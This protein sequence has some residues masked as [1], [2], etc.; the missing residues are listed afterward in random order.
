M[1][2]PTVDHP[3]TSIARWFARAC[4]V[5]PLAALALVAN[6]ASAVPAHAQAGEI[7]GTVTAVG[8]GELLAGAQ[9]TV[10]GGTQRAVTDDRGRFRLAGLTGTTATLEVRRIGYRL[11][12]VVARV[13]QTD[14]GVAL[15]VN[16]MSLEAVVVTGTTG[17]TERQAIGNA[18]TTINAAEVTE[19]APVNNMQQ[20]LNGRAAGVVI[21][22]SSGGVGTGSRVRVRGATSLSLSNEPLLYV[23]GIRVNNQAGTG[24]LSHSS[25][26][27]GVI[28]RLND[29]S[30][31]DIESIEILKGPAA[32]TLYGTEASSGVI[33][34]ITKKGATG[35]AR[36]SATARQGVNY[37]ANWRQYFPAN[38]G[39]IVTGGPVVE[40]SMDSLINANRGALFRTG[41]HQ[42]L[43]LALSGGTDRITYYASGSYLDSEGAEPTNRRRQYGGRINL[44]VAPSSRFRVNTTLGFVTGPTYV[45][46][47]GG[48]GGRVWT[49]LQASPVNYNNQFLH[50]FHSAIPYQYDMLF[51]L[52]QD[53][54]RFTGSVRLEHQPAG[55]LQ[56]R[57]TVGADRTR[58]GDN[59]YVPRIDSLIPNPNVGGSAQGSRS[60][61]I[62]TVTVRTVDYVATATLGLGPGFRPTTAGGTDLRFATSVGGQ[63]YHEATSFVFASGSIFPAPGLSSVNA[64][65]ANKS[66]GQDFVEDKS[67]GVY[68]QEQVSWKDRLFLT[69]ALRSDDHSA[70][71]ANFDRVIYPKYSASWVVSREPWW[72]FGTANSLRL[73][74]AYGEAGRAP[75]TYAAIRTYTPVTGPGDSPAITAQF[76]GN[77]D[78]G[79]ERGKEVELGFDAGALDDRVNVELTYYNKKTTK[80]ILNR[81]IAP[82]IGYTGTPV[83]NTG[84]QPFNAGSIRN[85][86]WEFLL[87]GTPYRTERVGI[88]LAFSFSTNDNKILDLGIPGFTFV[89]VAGTLYMRHQEGYPVGS[90][91]ERRVVAAQ[92]D[93]TG[94]PIANTV[95]C[96]DGAGGSV[97]CAGADL[98]YGTGDDAP[99]LFLG[100]AVPK[101]EGSFSS[102]VTLWNRI[103]LYGQVDFKTGW[104]KLDGNTRVRCWFFNRPCREVY[105]PLEYDPKRIAMVE[106]NRNLPEFF[107]SDASFTKFREF[108]VSYAVPEG[109]SRRANVNRASIS[110]SGRNLKT[111]TNYPGGEVETTYLYG[112]R[113][114]HSAWDQTILPQLTQW[115]VTVNLGF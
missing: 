108:T 90:W 59:S 61:T 103:R 54:D 33:N 6:L 63:F 73:R 85:T 105:F 38:Y 106:S 74:A 9:I 24:P 28:S 86:G 48:F 2:P 11:E 53:L 52:W 14:L 110:L 30:P 83:A 91:F 104:K 68:V 12:R 71:G 13:G 69:A 43:E 46:P 114:G 10:A 98:T 58:E 51:K 84:T 95:M 25:Q 107:I 47:E 60:E 97:L 77:P 65:T 75:S 96:D 81:E 45:S 88:D 111:W 36:W 1:R 112:P 99:V 39:R 92:L 20:L 66:Q 89:P 8:T 82:S 34:I 15:T 100:R 5:A 35:A 21:Q 3:A 41:K 18:V 50:G 49:T 56:H 55:W 80:A 42:E 27:S 4:S 76:L 32:A 102:T 115:L 29:I 57:F 40:V 109:L 17:A 23:D 44:G 78:L 72:M 67:L 113:G 22:Q 31:D 87:R 7:A 94:R 16:P 37:L 62:R 70:F 79:P 26:G 64:T 19:L 101:N 93:A